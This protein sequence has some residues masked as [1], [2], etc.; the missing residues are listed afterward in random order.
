MIR[1]DRRSVLKG[2]AAL[3]AVGVMP[4]GPRPG[5][6]AIFIY[7]GRFAASRELAQAWLVRGVPVLDPR[8]HDLG[9]A[10]RNHIPGLLREGCRIEGATL[11]SD[12][13]ICESF[14][15]AHGLAPSTHDLA[16]P[17]PA[18]LALRQW[19]LA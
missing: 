3:A 12:R 7:D 2:A 19:T 18:G 14:G 8:E 11:W 10:W 17:G 4:V 13:F 15:K 5:A 9:L 16:L 6:L 1:S